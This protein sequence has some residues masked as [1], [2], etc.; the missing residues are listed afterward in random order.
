MST[1]FLTAILII[2]GIIWALAS[3]M[4]YWL[5]PDLAFL[6]EILQRNH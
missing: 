6:R 2:A 4:I 3:V 5:V 1:S